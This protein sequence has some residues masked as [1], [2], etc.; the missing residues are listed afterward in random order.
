[1]T[2]SKRTSISR[3]TLGLFHAAQNPSPTTATAVPSSLQVPLRPLTAHHT[4][5][6]V[7]MTQLSVE[8]AE[9]NWH[10]ERSAVDS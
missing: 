10:S 9:E 6:K 8:Q 4:C 1:M 7:T 2:I 5:I 3:I